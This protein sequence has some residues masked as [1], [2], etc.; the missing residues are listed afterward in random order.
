MVRKK[1]NL[2]KPF[3]KWAG[4]KR[5]VIDEI[6]K[7][8]PE[9]ISTYYEPF[10][11]GGAV[12]FELQ[13]NKAVINDVNVHLYNVYNVIKN[14]VDEL[15]EDLKQ[16]KNEED[17]YY[18]MRAKDRTD[19]FN[20]M[21]DV[22]KASRILYL[23]K[24]CYNG[25]FRVNSSGEFNVPFGRYKNPSIVNEPV[26]RAVSHYLNNNNIAILNVDFE[27]AIKGMRKQAFVY[28]DPPYHPLSDTSSFTGYTLD[29]FDEK[30]QIRLR[31]LCDKLNKRGCRFLLSNSSAKFIID[32]YDHKDYK[33]DYV[34]ANRSI[35]S[36]ASSRGEVKEVLVRNY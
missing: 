29:G 8:I 4:G 33:I 30:D 27:E 10:V 15:I 7:Y 16:H 34:G 32:L 12:L 26:L 1:N 28:F 2:V 35:N 22:Q 23:N 3:V 18:K 5:Q 14:N 24:T 31:K 36:D 9:N 11:G 6:K 17:Y 21:T 19:E 25:L 13:P 20:G